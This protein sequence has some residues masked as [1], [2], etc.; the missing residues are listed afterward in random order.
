MST[1][2]I[3]QEI[4]DEIIARCDIVSVI[5]EYVPLKRKGSN[6]QGLC[7]FHNE[8]TPSFSVSPG[9]QIFHCFGCGKGGNVFRFIMDIEGISFLEA[10][11]KLA[12]RA[13][14]TL[15][16]KEMTAE[17][18][19]RMEQRKRYIQI[20]DFAARYYHKVLME[21]QQG[22]P[23]RDY[24]K[25]RQI[26][27]DIIVKFQLGATPDGWDNLYQALKKRGVTAQE[28][29]DLGLISESRKPGQYIDRFRQRLMFPIGDEKGNI[30]AFGGRIIDKDSSPQKYLNSPDTPL[31]HKSRNLYGLHLA[32]T[33][34]R[35]ADQAIIVE[36][37]MDVISC[38][39]YGITNAVAPLGTA[40][41]TDQGKL[42]MR[43][44]YQMGISF[45]GD[46]AG[47][48]ATMRCLD[49]LSDL[50]CTARVIQI[51]DQSDP[52]EYLKKHGKEAFER[53][54]AEAQE[55][56]MYKIARYMETTNTDTITG[57]MKVVSMLLPDLRKMQ[58]AVARETAIREIS[59][60]LAVSEKAVWD[61][62]RHGSE[63][64]AES[65]RNEEEAPVSVQEI[66]QKAGNIESK[67]E[68]NILH[69]LFDR[70]DL[71][72]LVERYGGAALFDSAG[73]GMYQEFQNSIR[74]CGKVDSAGITQEKGQLLADL[75][76]EELHITDQE[77]FMNNAL[78][79]LKSDRLDQEYQRL[80]Q[81]LTEITK[82]GE[83]GNMHEILQQLDNIRR[84]KKELETSRRGE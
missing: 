4:L 36:G 51:P 53:L 63:V 76:M 26:S 3:P 71:L 57:K 15:P 68:K 16:E 82:V 9:K 32:R 55:L 83:T 42:L 80:S 58:S 14:V 35:N 73:A 7:P 38:H 69:I 13:N 66:V 77:K 31:F 72:D 23:Y 43:N 19:K 48:K 54:I 75:L 46:A 30:I 2:Y 34:I 18:R 24:L 49:I 44:T 59:I 39:Q 29:L 41:T 81:K 5:N 11:E 61:E 64:S 74:R 56:I 12:K 25:K 45:D 78:M 21:S 60:R 50:G 33:G 20:N 1:G 37:Y 22:R 10:V 6:Y 40:F 84:M 47:V 65:D 62:L 17:Q 8:K 70:P 28:M 27:D 52:D 67:V 79:Q